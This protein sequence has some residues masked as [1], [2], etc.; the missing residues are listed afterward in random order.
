MAPPPV[1]V[2]PLGPPAVGKSALLN[3]V[4]HAGLLPDEACTAHA[5]GAA[6]RPRAPACEEG[7]RLCP[8]VGT[9]ADS[10]DACA[11]NAFLFGNEAAS[12]AVATWDARR[13]MEDEKL[14]FYTH[15]M[16]ALHFGDG[17]PGSGSSSNSGGNV[18]YTPI[19]TP[20]PIGTLPPTTALPCLVC[21]AN[22]MQGKCVLRY[23]D[24]AE[25]CA[26][27]ADC[28]TFV[29][30]AQAEL[31]DQREEDA[32]RCLGQR[33]GFI[34]DLRSKLSQRRITTAD[35]E[36]SLKLPARFLPLLGTVRE[37][38]VRVVPQEPTR[39]GVSETSATLA[40]RS[41]STSGAA[42]PNACARAILDKLHL[43]LLRTATG[44]WS[45]WGLLDIKG[46]ARSSATAATAS[47]QCAI[48]LYVPARLPVAALIDMPGIQPAASAQRH[49]RSRS[50]FVHALRTAAVRHPIWMPDASSPSLVAT[51][52]L[53]A[54]A[55][56]RVEQ[57]VAAAPWTPG[58]GAA[59][60]MAVAV[61]ATIDRPTFDLLDDAGA[62]D[63]WLAPRGSP[64]EAGGADTSGAVLWIR[65]R[66]LSS[67]CDAAQRQAQANAFLARQRRC[68][69]RS[70]LRSPFGGGG[71]T[72]TFSVPAL[73]P[74]FIVDCGTSPDI[75]CLLGYLRAIGGGA[76]SK[77]RCCTATA[78]AAAA[79]SDGS[80][81]RARRSIITVYRRIVA[82]YF[83]GA[84]AAAAA[85]V[86]FAP[87]MEL[88]EEGEEEDGDAPPNAVMMDING[89]DIDPLICDDIIAALD[90][91]ASE[92]VRAPLLPAPTP[93]QNEDEPAREA[94]ARGDSEAAAALQSLVTSDLPD[95]P[96]TAT[97]DEEDCL[98]YADAAGEVYSFAGTPSH[99][100]YSRRCHAGTAAAA[101]GFTARL[102]SQPVAAAAVETGQ[103]DGTATPSRSAADA[104]ATALAIL[105]SEV[106]PAS[107]SSPPPTGNRRRRRAPVDATDDTEATSPLPKAQ[108]ALRP[109]AK[110]RKADATAAVKTKE[111]RTPPPP[112][113]PPKKVVRP[114]PHRPSPERPSA[115]AP[116]SAT[117][118][119]SPQPAPPR[120]AVSLP[121]L[122]R[123][124]KRRL[125]SSGTPL[126]R[127]TPR[128]TGGGAN[129]HGVGG[130]GGW[131]Q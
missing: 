102:W 49:A 19:S 73:P 78:A 99:S 85:P 62:W 131:W 103:A 35:A 37:Y 87:A 17:V 90:A 77:T 89:E 31:S 101:V 15:P 98:R 113:P 119:P 129:W 7:S 52:G 115:V 33:P 13:C 10:V 123:I 20:L 23:R 128:R 27:I 86:A 118:V 92:P 69:A 117:C 71:D 107:V 127:S 76:Y 8:A 112:P 121:V 57:I 29:L 32:C 26:L 46:P 74:C 2:A 125:A 12:A 16:A 43:F 66:L 51:A 34:F 94:N 21:S 48:E 88:D 63:A 67:S 41:A 50:A 96:L 24:R 83:G 1:A 4:V 54:D 80:M 122:P 30:S 3:A 59:A 9:A 11:I 116:A 111:M 6:A 22:A 5:G 60:A 105:S 82:A 56:A 28:H 130:A 38:V 84:P 40:K 70:M 39:A 126:R 18:P 58:A 14:A 124:P 53:D 68:L 108:R 93:T 72:A 61:A 64:D 110:A 36:A 97:D 81:S 104:L 120:T 44:P 100:T 114:K 106:A 47:M 91:H 65:N 55:V 79:P 109:S 75:R 42:R 45:H 25:V 95:V